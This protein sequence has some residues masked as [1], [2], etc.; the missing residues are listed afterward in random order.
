MGKRH[1]AIGIKQAIRFEWMQKAA[2]L[3]LA[4][5]DAKTIRQELHEFLADRK[6]NGSAGERGDTSRTQAVNILMNAWV[7]PQKE[8]ISFR[9]AC[10]ENL[11]SDPDPFNDLAI[12][13]SV[14]NAS[15]PFWNSVAKVVG[16]LLSLQNQVSQQQVFNRLRE[17]HGD[18]ETVSRCARHV[19]RSLS[20]WGILSDCE[21]KGCYQIG[22]KI[23]IHSDY[24]ISLLFE[25]ILLSK[26]DGISSLADI[27]SSPGLF[28]FSFRSLNGSL[29]IQRSQRVTLERYG[30]DEEILRLKAQ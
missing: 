11:E 20:Y 17:R 30:L 1:E 21:A 13:W 7:V 4:G 16:R 22:N 19:I 12:H 28:P 24:T 25:S 6:G 15:Y 8:L 9:D 23:P 18:R 27:Q 26:K 10:L 29:I 2:N 3:L 14:I 5:L